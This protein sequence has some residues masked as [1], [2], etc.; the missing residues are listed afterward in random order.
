MRTCFHTAGGARGGNARGSA[1]WFDY[2]S[3]WSSKGTWGNVS[4]SFIAGRCAGGW[5]VQ[6]RGVVIDCSDHE[7]YDVKRGGNSRR[8]L[9]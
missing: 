9:R 8:D 1:D 5:S 3:S 6:A 2:V 7:A 4:P